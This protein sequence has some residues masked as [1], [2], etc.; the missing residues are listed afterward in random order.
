MR[1]A[2]FLAMYHVHHSPADGT[3]LREEADTA[4]VRHAIDE[5]GVEAIMQIH[6]SDAIGA[7]QAHG[8]TPGNGQAFSLQISASGTDLFESAR[9]DDGSMDA[10]PATGFQSLRGGC[11]RNDDHSQFHRVGDSSNI[12]KTG[13]AQNLPGAG[14]DRVHSAR[15]AGVNEVA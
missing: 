4:L 13:L 3:G 11:C 8:V 1:E 14:I 9:D 15:V 7:D 6:G 5:G 10:A 2:H 12:C